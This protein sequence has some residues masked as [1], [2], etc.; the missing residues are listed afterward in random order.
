[1][2]DVAANPLVSNEMRPSGSIPGA[3]GAV[4]LI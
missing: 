2:L 1:L 4:Q 3:S